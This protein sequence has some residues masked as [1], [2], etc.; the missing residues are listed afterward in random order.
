MQQLRF[1]YMMIIV[2]ILLIIILLII[3]CGGNSGIITIPTTSPS[4]PTSTPQPSTT[5]LIPTSTPQ[6]STTSSIPTSTPQPTATSLIP[7]SVPQPPGT[8]SGFVMSKIGLDVSFNKV[9]IIMSDT[10]PVLSNYVPVN[11]AEVYL[12][13]NP[14]IKAI[15]D[16]TG[17]FLL[18][19]IS[20]GTE[21]RITKLMVKVNALQSKD[22]NMLQTQHGI[23]YGPSGTMIDVK[24]IP[25]D[26]LPVSPGD[27]RQLY[28]YG[29][30]SSDQIVNSNNGTWST[31]IGQIDPH[32]GIF[33]APST[34]GNGKITYTDGNFSKSINVNVISSQNIGSVSGVVSSDNK[35]GAGLLVGIDILTSVAITN[36]NG[37]YT[38]M[39]VPSGQNKVLAENSG[40]NIAQQATTVSSGH[41]TS[42]PIPVGGISINSFVNG[43]IQPST[44]KIVCKA[45]TTDD[46]VLRTGLIPRGETTI[47]FEFVGLTSITKLDFQGQDQNGNILSRSIKK[48]NIPSGSMGVYNAQLLL[49]IEIVNSKFS[50]RNIPVSPRDVL[51]FGN[52][53]DER[54]YTVKFSIDANDVILVINPGQQVSYTL[55][56][57]IPAST[58]MY[59]YS[60]STPS[61][62]PVDTGIFYSN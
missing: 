26:T 15:T 52:N 27:A 10:T 5:S 31:T 13:Y 38:L 36:E 20:Y 28:G 9:I 16:S 1:L 60:G 25:L 6:P 18:T 43:L 33:Q 57:S 22:I 62:S 54:I 35:P 3:G 49:G 55:P 11:S 24:T 53:S 47:R 4:E 2:S 30:T 32:T 58:T 50:P 39:N 59:L 19:N 14:S 29:I 42:L 40:V 34:S 56:G 46:I 44:D 45:L 41:T 51:Y 21:S 23:A 37:I 8:I 48:L 7:T 17:H 12:S 61:G